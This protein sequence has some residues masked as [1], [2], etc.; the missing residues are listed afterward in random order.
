MRELA[1]H[2]MDIMENGLD[3][4]ADLLTVSICEDRERNLLEIDIADNGR[5][6]DAET[7]K[8][9]LDPFFT[10][11]KTRRVGLGLSLLREACRRCGGDMEVRSAPGEGTRVKA[12]FQADH[13]DLAPM[14]DVGG[15]L[16]TLIM[17]NHH[18]D[19]VYTHRVGDRVFEVDTREMREELE[20]VAL[21]HPDVILFLRD[22]I[23]QG[24]RRV[25][26]AQKG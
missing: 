9:A 16:T 17:G 13:I 6:M 25:C 2:V 21:N 5:G 20:G 18:V 4:G 14:G 8:R 26:G 15:A 3:A 22:T 10:T 23:R 12:S 11:R 19:I 24:I 7:L 1:L